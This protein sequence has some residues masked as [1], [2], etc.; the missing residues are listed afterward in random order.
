MTSADVTAASNFFGWV[1]SDAAAASTGITSVQ[2]SMTSA[3]SQPSVGVSSVAFA[4][5]EPSTYAL[6]GLAVTTGGL[7]RIR[8]RLFGKKAA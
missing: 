5:P 7:C 3:A 2:I 4:V 8:R 1:V 6:L